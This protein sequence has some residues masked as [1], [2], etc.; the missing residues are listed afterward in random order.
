[1][2]EDE[3]GAA[4][5]RQ[6]PPGGDETIH[7]SVQRLI[8]SGKDLAHAELA[9]AKLKGRSLAAILRRALLFGLLAVVGLMVGLSLSLVAGIVALAPHVGLLPATLIVIAV[10]FGM[11]LIFGLLARHAL[12]RLMGA[13]PS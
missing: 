4:Y 11:A 9:W 8:A 13:D 1:M 6:E 2:D 12:R 7:A 10:A 3:A 5:A